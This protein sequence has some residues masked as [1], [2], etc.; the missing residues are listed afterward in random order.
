MTPSLS[1]S[2]IPLNRVRALAVLLLTL[3]SG[4]ASGQITLSGNFDHGSLDLANSSVAGSFVQLAG[5]DNF[6]PGQWKWLYFSADGVAGEAPTFQIDD[7]FVTG[8]GNLNDHEMVYSY[9]QDEWFFF[10]NNARNAA[11]DTFTF[12]NNAAFANDRVYVAYG[13]PYSVGRAVNH[14]AAIASSPWVAPTLSGDANLVVGQS[15][16]GFDDLGRGVP[17]QDLYG[18]RITDPD[19]T[20]AKAKVVLAGGV[21]SNETL[22][23]HTLEAMVDYLLGDTL[24]AGLLRRR[25]EFYVYPMVNPDGRLAGYNRSTVE[26]P[27][28]DPNRF[29]DPPN[30]GGQT[31]IEAIGE[32]MIADTGGDVDFFI[33][34][35]STVQKGSGHFAFIDLDRNFHLNP[36]WQ[37]FLELE[38]TVGESDASLINNTGAKF[39]LEQLDAGFTITFETRFLAGENEDRFVTLGQNFGQ[40]FADVLATPF[41]DLDFD[42]FVGGD[43]WLIFTQFAETETTGL[44]AIAS[45]ARGD[46]NQDGVVDVFDFG[47][48]KEAYEAE[49]G[50]SAF[51]RLLA[52]VPE[53][54]AGTLLTLAMTLLATQTRPIIRG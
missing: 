19:A 13:L 9:D 33:D 11:A 40:A 3:A 15:P 39:G 45:Y 6:N 18:Y 25:A 53:P 21:H 38:P 51:A 10:D 30:Y 23:N 54:G 20:N 41:G 12:S 1:V 31:E 32:A 14:V 16:G 8:G 42:G 44:S 28:L 22:G 47:L 37:R 52:G 27:N 36:V 50:A 4:V 17:Q 7:D 26:E 43:D 2:P 48:F 5:R 29:W 46:L 24:E 34:F 35:H 49:N